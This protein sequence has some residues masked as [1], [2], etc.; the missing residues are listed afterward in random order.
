MVESVDTLDLKF[1][2]RIQVPQSLLS[3]ESNDFLL[4]H[5]L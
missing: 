2:I 4:L 3:N 1:S 5:N